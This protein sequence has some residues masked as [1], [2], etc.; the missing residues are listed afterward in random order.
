MGFNVTH[1]YGMTESYGPSTFRAFQEEWKDLPLAERAA[2]MARQGVPIVTHSDADV[3]DRDDGEP[4]PPTASASAKLVMRSN[5]I[6]R[7]YLKDEATSDH[8]LRNGWLHSGDLGVK[9]PDGYIEMKDRAKDIIISGG[10]NIASLEIEEV[11]YSHPQVM[12]AAVVAR[13][14]D[15]WG[16]SPCAFVTLK[17]DAEGK[18]ER[19]GHHRLLPPAH[20]G[21][22]DPEAPS[23]SARCPRPRRARSRN[24]C[25]ANRRGRFRSEMQAPQRKASGQAVSAAL[26]A[27]AHRTGLNGGQNRMILRI[28]PV[29]SILVTGASSGLGRHFATGSRRQGATVV[30]AARRAGELGGSLP[31]SAAGG[32][33]HAVAM[34]VTDM[35][36]VKAGVAEA[37]R[38]TGGLDG[39]INNS[40]M[41]G[42]CRSSTRPKRAGTASS[43]P[44]SKAY[45]RSAPR[46]RGTW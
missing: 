46:S 33:A 36:S 44:I 25:C 10:E 14:D 45:G 12:E 35:A 28:F 31:R 43:T 24:S 34:D 23:F 11:L 39:L 13:P 38:L 21:L 41:S 20:G 15:K 19:R 16:E 26:D 29:K 37:V 7:G 18:V 22:Q 32:N 5:T 17:P 3:V 1:L 4:C 27:V 2:K 42:P 8:T 6:M 40:G 30:A 9:H